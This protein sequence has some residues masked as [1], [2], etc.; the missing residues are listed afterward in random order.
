MYLDSGIS[1][2]EML[3]SSNNFSEY[4][5]Q[6]QY[7]DS[8]KDKIQTAMSSI[9]QIQK[10]LAKQQEDVTNLLASQ[11]TQNAQLASSRD[12]VSNLLAT[13]SQNVAAANASVKNSNAQISSLKAQQAAILAAASRSYGGSIPG[14]SSGSGGACDNGHGN[15][16]YPIAWC[17]APQ[18]AYGFGGVWGYNRECV[19]WAGWRRANMGNP[20]PAGWGNANSWDEG[21]RSAG[22]TVNNTPS[23][24]AI[25]QTNAG[26]YGHVAIVEA[27]SG[28]N[29]IVSEMN[30]DGYGHFR[31]GTYSIG[32]FQ[33][34]H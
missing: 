32:Y 18:D 9:L 34:I 11:R 23:V 29:V 3:A 12:E 4:F 5:N 27:I 21:A 22:F 30:Y 7:Q 10:D 8:I 33:Y 2:L 26:A 14:A 6:Q 1:P 25:A 28:G 13:A 31:Y 15:G 16:G 24:G 17:N 20:V 19:S